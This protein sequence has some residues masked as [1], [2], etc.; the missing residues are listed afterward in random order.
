MDS[1]NNN[2][3]SSQ[4][5]LRCVVIGATT[6]LIR[7]TEIL[8][9]KGHEVLAVVSADD[10]VKRWAIDKEVRLVD[11]KDGFESFLKSE[12]FDYLFSIVNERILSADVLQSASKCSINY[13][14]A[15]LPRYAG[16][17]ATSW[18][19]LNQ[20]TS[21]GVSWHVISEQ[22]DAGD[23]LKQRSVAIDATETA[24]T[25]N[26][27]CYEAAIDSFT[28]LIDELST[29]TAVPIKQNLS[30]R[31]FF[32]RHRR[33]P[34]AGIV[35]WNRPAEQIATLVRALDFG[36]HPNALGLA[37]TLTESGCYLV[38]E[39]DVLN[40]VSRSN[41][42]T[43]ISLNGEQA[44]V[45]TGTHDVRVQLTNADGQS[46][47][48]A[49]AVEALHAGDSFLNPHSDITTEIEDLSCI[50]SEHEKFWVR[51]L[52]NLQSTELPYAKRLARPG[53]SYGHSQLPWT[54]PAHIVNFIAQTNASNP[55]EFILSAWCA[56]IS[57]LSQKNSF[58]LALRDEKQNR[59]LGNFKQIFSSHIPLAVNV[60]EQQSIGALNWQLQS[61]LETLRRHKTYSRDVVARYP[62]LRSLTKLD[63]SPL[64]LSVELDSDLSFSKPDRELTLTIAGNGSECRLTYASEVFSAEDIKRMTHQ[65]ET[66]LGAYVQDT[67]N[68]IAL[69]PLLSEAE[70]QQVLVDW[71]ATDTQI[72]TTK[73]IH[74]FFETQ[75]IKAPDSIAAVFERQT[76]TY[77]ELNERSNQLARRLQKL[78]IGPEKLVG[79]CANR[80]LD[81]LVGMLG[82]LKAG[83]AY[84]PLDPAY[85]EDRLAFIVEDSSLGLIV[86]QEELL[87]K[88]PR[89]SAEIIC[90][91]SH[92]AT[93]ATESAKDPTSDVSSKNLAYLIYTSGSTGL[94]K[95]VAIQHSSAVALI[96]W[97]KGVF[98][99]EDLSGVLASTS[100]CFDLSVF[101][102]FVTLSCGGPVIL[103]ENALHL[104]SLPAASQVSLIN[105]VPSAI[106][107]LIRMKAIPE[108]VKI[109]NLAGEPLQTSLVQQIYSQTN[110]QRVY[111]LYGPSEDTTYSTFT[112]RSPDRAATIGRPISNTQV[113]LLDR[114]RQPVPIGVPGELY[115]GGAG[116]ARE[117]LNRPELTNEKFVPDPFS[118]TPGARLYRTGDLARYF[119][120]G[121]LEYLGRIDHQVKIRGF[122]IELG[123]I[124]TVLNQPKDLR[125]SVVVALEDES[126]IKT[127]A[128]YVVPKKGHAPTIVEL[129]DYLKK[130]LPAFMVPSFFTVLDSIPLTP[131]GKVDR[132]ALPAPENKGA[133]LPETFVGPSDDLERNLVRM[134]EEILNTQPIGVKDNFFE[135]GGHS[136]LAVEMFVR[137]ESEYG[138]KIPLATLFQTPTV[139]QLASLL[140]E[141]REDF[142]LPSLVPIQPNGSRSRFFCVHARGGNVLFYRDLAKRLGNA[143]PFY[144][145]Q[146]QGIEGKKPRHSRVEEM[147]AHYIS[148][149]RTIQPTGPFYIGGASFGGTAAYEMANQ[150]RA[151]GD[152][153][154]LLALFDTTAPGYPRL[155][156]ETSRMRS[157]VYGFIRRCQYQ[158][159]S[160]KLLSAE[161]RAAYLKLRLNKAKVRTIRLSKM[162]TRRVASKFPATLRRKIFSPAT[163]APWALLEVEKVITQA[164]KSYVH[165]KY[166]GK[167]T[168]FRASKQPLGIYPDPTLGWNDLVTG[169]LEIHEVP[170]YH[171]AIVAEPY[172][173]FL[174][175]KLQDCL[176]KAQNDSVSKETR[177]QVS[178]QLAN[179]ATAGAQ[180]VALQL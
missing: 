129:R 23:I 96:D 130:R 91:D 44:V 178:G 74:D 4:R 136:L 140:R 11:T 157:R 40:V 131:N 110:V 52:T 35:S 90:V 116:L 82:I 79:I 31:K 42:G 153:V 142:S 113:Y 33:P 58:D 86:T 88:L 149:I 154:A 61:E 176:A 107:E 63:R 3:H 167:L 75:A 50:C 144:G 67:E 13:H 17:H 145:L 28:E 161:E 21:H 65:F 102:I 106:A 29:D 160:F 99:Q 146:L 22:V 62:S 171:G 133:E 1:L 72:S 92:R 174:A 9:R 179:A 45:S 121:N 10:A 51:R 30:A 26:T 147:A 83:G 87:K 14:D 127:L 155:L 100:I 94:P 43:I 18:A 8:T 41:P 114:H 68:P 169:E 180:S 152:E 158:S 77:R 165:P 19:L 123:E 148:E 20:E 166:A 37:K 24:F 119:P 118:K 135:L 6:L 109:V 71:N 175:V 54:I 168:L 120:D 115:L 60:D 172:V 132:R 7:C 12:S 66:F 70:R 173:Q 53:T 78:V 151:Q 128:A 124:E 93:W 36:P 76:I 177:D 85:P 138:K 15:P 89:S 103:A 64:Q 80:S 137:I 143:Q 126:G 134:W 164:L 2:G 105:T 108:T 104:A 141:E 69:L 27:K 47:E 38:K 84:V 16:T 111:D 163:L 112:L 170:G 34:D 162:Y 57:R 139:E 48:N 49:T 101:E 55:A 125:D 73:C 46:I 117:Y 32:G 159:A 39:I 156:P 59:D 98:S 150:L 81:L 95:G 122:R 5:P 97:A 56:F 25:L